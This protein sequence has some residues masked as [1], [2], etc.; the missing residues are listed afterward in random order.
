MKLIVARHPAAD[1]RRP[2]LGRLRGARP[3]AADRHVRGALRLLLPLPVR[4]RELRAGD[5][6]GPGLASRLWL[7]LGRLEPYPA[8]RGAVRADL[9]RCCGSSMPSAGGRWAC[10]ASRRS[11]SASTTRAATSSRPASAPALHCLRP[12][13]AD[14]A[15]VAVAEQRRRSHRRLV[16]LA[17]QARLA[18]DGAARPLGMVRRR[19]ARRRH[20]APA[21]VDRGLAAGDL[22][23]QPRRLLPVPD[24]RLHPAAADRVRLRLCRHAARALSVRDRHRRDPLQG[25]GELQAPAR[26]R[27]CRPRLLPGP[28]R[29][30]DRTAPGSTTRATTASSRRS[31]MSRTARGW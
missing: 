31:T 14:R 10:S 20:P 7:R 8:A 19:R 28:H 5:G 25:A 12:A 9:A 21:L 2:V 17:A 1:R 15:D 16:Q 26:D 29:R 24:P 6:A 23:A 11:W 4:L 3:G 22:V 27:H 18:D 13:A 30:L